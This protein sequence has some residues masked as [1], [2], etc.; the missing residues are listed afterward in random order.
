[1]KTEIFIERLNSLHNDENAFGF[2]INNPLVIL[3]LFQNE[4][5]PNVIDLKRFLKK[6]EKEKLIE[7]TYIPGNQYIM[8]TTYDICITNRGLYY[9]NKKFKWFIR[10]FYRLENLSKLLWETVVIGFALIKLL[11]TILETI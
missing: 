9:H 6:K 11:E 7:I 2:R 10:N 5:L 1:M 8:G 3:R 4:N